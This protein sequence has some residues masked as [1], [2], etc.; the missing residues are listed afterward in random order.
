MLVKDR[1]KQYIS[2][3]EKY[4]SVT[5]DQMEFEHLEEDFAAT[6]AGVLEWVEETYAEY[7]I[8]RRIYYVTID[9]V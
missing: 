5:I 4:G 7:D 3:L 9:I 8:Y 6:V 2:E 1:I